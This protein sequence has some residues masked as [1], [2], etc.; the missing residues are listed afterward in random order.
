MEKKKPTLLDLKIN[1]CLNKFYETMN[2]Y[3]QSAGLKKSHFA[4]A[5][6]MHNE[7]NYS[8]AGDIAKLCCLTM[9]NEKFRQI[10]KESSREVHSSVFKGHVYKW[11][12]TNYLLK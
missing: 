7:N 2:E 10:V 3:G 11:E 9:K 8:T 1:E 12:N 5:H 6:G 4:V